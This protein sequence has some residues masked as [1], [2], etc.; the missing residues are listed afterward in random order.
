M[1]MDNSRISDEQ[2]QAWLKER[3]DA[4]FFVKAFPVSFKVLNDEHRVLRLAISD[5]RR[6]RDGDIV[7]QLGIDTSEYAQNPV[8]FMGRGPK[9][10]NSGFPIARSIKVYRKYSSDHLLTTYS[11]D[12]FA[13][14]AQGHDEAELAYALARDGFLNTASIGFRPTLVKD[15]PD[16]VL[17]ADE[18]A[19]RTAGNWVRGYDIRKSIKY[20]HTLVGIP[21]NIGAS[22][23]RNL[24]K[25]GIKPGDRTVSDFVEVARKFIKG[26]TLDAFRQALIGERE[27]I[28]IGAFSV[29]KAPSDYRE[30]LA[31]SVD[32]S[33]EIADP[34]FDAWEQWVG[35]KSQSDPDELP[36]IVKSAD[37]DPEPPV[38]PSP[39][40]PVVLGADAA[41]GADVTVAVVTDVVPDA[42]KVIEDQAAVIRELSDR[43]AVLEK[44]ASQPVV[45]P[46][47]PTPSPLNLDGLAEKFSKELV[48][49]ESRTARLIEDTILEVWG[50]KEDEVAQTKLARIPSVDATSDP[51]PVAKDVQLPA[52]SEKAVTGVAA[53]SSAP[54]IQIDPQLIASLAPAIA[55]A[56]DIEGVVEQVIYRHRGGISLPNGG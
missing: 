3:A 52:R 18:K 56:L 23:Q 47:A 28:T 15:L 34:G 4:R 25:C 5:E 26:S 8:V 24:E 48:D 41:K 54:A 55:K 44:A 45:A 49:S 32:D 50:R 31:K 53:G 21:S 9:H 40:E 36:T 29:E 1:T 19:A 33:P 37:A 30:S 27:L 39:E 46:V 6:D 20:E 14:D 7:R 10:A 38:E 17:T 16:D 42:T 13:G 11:D 12:M 22:V 35:V 2:I 51:A 43:I